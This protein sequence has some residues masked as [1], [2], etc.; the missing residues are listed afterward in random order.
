MRSLWFKLTLAFVLVAVVAVGLVALLL[1]QGTQQE[2]GLYVQRGGRQRALNLAPTLADYYTQN[3]SWQGVAGLLASAAPA[4]A[5]TPTGGAGRG[6]MG[7]GGLMAGGMMATDA[8]IL[9]DGSGL[10]VADTSGSLVGQRLSASVL[11]GGVSVVADGRTV[12]TLLVDSTAQGMPGMSSPLEQDFLAAINRYL[13][14]AG[15]L[16]VAVALVL[17]LYLSWRIT[18][19]LRAMTAAAT[20]LAGGDLKQRVAVRS[21]DEVGQLA[22]AFNSMAEGM[23]R[24]QELRRNMVADIA[25][26]LRTPLTVLQGNLEALR[27]G[28]LPPSP[29]TLTSLHSETLLL[30]RL[31]SDLR[32]LSLAEAGQLKLQ[33]APADMAELARQAVESLRTGAA[34]RGVS[35]ALEVQGDLPVVSVD[36]DRIGQVL[37][38]LMENSVRHSPPGGEVR[39]TVTRDTQAAG[40][41]RATVAD[42]GAGIPTEEL[43][44]V[45]ERFYR[46]DP[47]RA[48]STG[49][50][51]L[52]LAIV[53]LLVEAHGGRV[54]AESEPGQG[55]R[56]VF[57][58]PTGPAPAAHLG[59]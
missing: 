56:F 25:H 22:N 19:P 32:E 33:P 35:L 13:V 26:E 54:W 28:V 44:L 7:R 8:V 50:A 39:L 59:S 38:N 24:N 55:A 51:G 29:E 53:K 48:R 2:F 11:A 43:E 46:A 9:A 58:I 36:G 57:T 37:R 40:G 16:A 47:S 18:T 20:A 15:L 4:A 52:G 23:A 1:A 10:V 27:D 34:A 14:L 30:A 45:F 5:G 3:K 41:L 49:G 42:Q 31:V 17:S 12:G 6:M 21:G